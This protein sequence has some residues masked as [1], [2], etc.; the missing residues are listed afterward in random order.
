MANV[1]TEAESF[2]ETMGS[3]FGAVMTIEIEGSPYS[4]TVAVAGREK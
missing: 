4:N 2:I 1:I 3:V